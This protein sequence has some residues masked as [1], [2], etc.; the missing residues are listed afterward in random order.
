[1]KFVG[2]N[3]GW[4]VGW[5]GVGGELIIISTDSHKS[6]VCIAQERNRIQNKNSSYMHSL[7]PRH[8]SQIF[9]VA[10][11]LGIGNRDELHVG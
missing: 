10:G 11:W 3:E 9:N 5:G 2:K 6:M 7:V 4:E 1:M 8:H